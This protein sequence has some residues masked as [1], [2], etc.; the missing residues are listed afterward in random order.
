MMYITILLCNYHIYASY[1]LLYWRKTA[2]SCQEQAKPLDHFDI[3]NSEDK[4]VFGC[5]PTR[6][7]QDLLRCDGL[8]SFMAWMVFS[9]TTRL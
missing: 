5:R 4:N 8:T 2:M 1:H 7:T 3:G 9:T 6:I